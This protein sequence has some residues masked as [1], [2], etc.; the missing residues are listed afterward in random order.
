MQPGW[1]HILDG[2]KPSPSG[3]QMESAVGSWSSYHCDGHVNSC[4]TRTAYKEE[5]WPWEG[6][7]LSSGN[8]A[9][10]EMPVRTALSDSNE[11]RPIDRAL[12][13]SSLN[14]I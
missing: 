10:R 4:P 8:M 11:S 5:V 1:S 13:C 12:H 14:S 9:E 6:C 3:L 2:A 7:V